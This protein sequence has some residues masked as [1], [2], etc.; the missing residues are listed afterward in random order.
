MQTWTQATTYLQLVGI[1]IGQ[2]SFGFM[3]DWIG[4]RTAALID[5]AIILIG[6]VMLTVS[7]GTTI[8]GCVCLPEQHST[9]PLWLALL[10]YSDPC[11]ILLCGGTSLLTLCTLCRW[12][13][14]YAISQLIFGIGIGGEVRSQLPCTCTSYMAVLLLQTL[15]AAP[16]YCS[17]KPARHTGS[18]PDLCMCCCS[19]PRPA[20]APQ[21]R[22]QRTMRGVSAT[23]GARS[24]CPTPCRFGPLSL[25][26]PCAVP[27][28]SPACVRGARVRL[29]ACVRVR[30]LLASSACMLS[31]CLRVCVCSCFWP[32]LSA[33]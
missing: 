19:T 32:I 33:C 11:S 25:S 2:L 23:V 31:F 21:R 28:S 13:V 29:P 12:V 14:M 1:L 22:P 20:H 3:G 26:P 30:V 17:C 27:F 4:R 18:L 8:Q 10:S 9:S 16:Q 15:Q 6:V 24:C 7:N 5:M